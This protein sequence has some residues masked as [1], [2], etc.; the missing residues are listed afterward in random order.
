MLG[1][2]YVFKRFTSH[3]VKA[4]EHSVGFVRQS[5]RSRRHLLPNSLFD[6]CFTHLH[7][8]KQQETPSWKLNSDQS[9]SRQC[10]FLCIADNSEWKMCVHWRPGLTWLLQLAWDLLCRPEWSPASAPQV[11]GVKANTTTPQMQTIKLLTTSSPELV[12]YWIHPA[13]LLTSVLYSVHNT[14]EI[15]SISILTYFTSVPASIRPRPETGFLC[16]AVAIL[17]LTL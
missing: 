15:F 5:I 9:L 1:K 6:A 11:L 13:L 4:I 8:L 14:K 7:L 10:I 3:W 16:V 12:Y 17:K 2:I